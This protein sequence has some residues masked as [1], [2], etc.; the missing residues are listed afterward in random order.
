MSVLTL[1]A[2]LCLLFPVGPP[3]DG[4]A[5]PSPAAEAADPLR[6]DEAVPLTIGRLQYGG[7]GDW[8]ANPSSLPNLLEAIRTRTGIPVATREE[9]V[10]PLD[11]SLPD[12]PLIHMSGHGEVVFEAEERAALRR[13]LEGGG[14]LHADDNYGMDEAF[15]REMARLYPDRP[16]VELPPD[17]AIFSAFYEFPEGL[18]KIHEHDGESPQAFGIFE[19]GRLVVLYTY[20]TD[21]GNGWEDQEVHGNPPELREEALRMGVNIFV[22][23]VTRRIP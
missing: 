10:T 2:S 1:L 11:P 9:V 16:M 15:R 18:P 3:G 13:Y 23:A 19:D 14:L 7:G 5:F 20:E 12:F 17:H 6:A 22:H 4:W 21:L 8:Y